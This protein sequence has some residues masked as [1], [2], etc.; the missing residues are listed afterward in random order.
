MFK[1][2]LVA[3]DGSE[4]SKHAINH[5][6]EL[7]LKLGA[8]LMILTVIPPTSSLLYPIEEEVTINLDEYDKAMKEA[9]LRVLIDAETKTKQNYPHLKVTTKLAE[10]HVSS[11]IVEQAKNE[12][13]DLIVMGS[14]GLSG[15]TSWVLGS[16]SKH[17]VDTCNCPIL[18]VK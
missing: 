9:H 4:P 5:A 6:S 11:T 8:E 15:I 13:V 2:I 18:I 1:K 16:T 17:V 7:A 12:N 3:I 10:G 14:R